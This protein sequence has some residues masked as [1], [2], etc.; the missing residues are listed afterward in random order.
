MYIQYKTVLPVA[1]AASL[2]LVGC[3]G[4]D[5]THP[6]DGTWQA[7]YPTADLSLISDTKVVTCN[8]PPATLVIR[9]S[10][11]TTTQNTTCTTTIIIPATSTT[12]A[13]ST[14]Y[15]PQTTYYNISVLIGPNS[16]SGE[17]DVMDA[18]VNGVTFTG[19]CISTIACSAVSASG[20]T[21]GV[22]R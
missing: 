6:Y 3:G 19:Q 10:A 1:F 8:T 15:A 5:N 2:L 17:K 22:T 21:L 11:G 9:N 13:V 7:V 16:V 12:P 4:G 14:T 20:A 18:I